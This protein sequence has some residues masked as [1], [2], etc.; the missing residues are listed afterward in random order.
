VMQQ[1]HSASSPSSLEKMKNNRE[2]KEK[3]NRD[4]SF[5]RTFL[6]V[7]RD[8]SENNIMSMSE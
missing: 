5:S 8:S 1:S 4:P 2:K 3:E 6:S 7:C